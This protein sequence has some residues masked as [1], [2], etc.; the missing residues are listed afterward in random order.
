MATCLFFF[1]FSLFFPNTDQQLR[2]QHARLILERH[3]R[4]D[5]EAVLKQL[6]AEVDSLKTKQQTLINENNQLSLKV[7]FRAKEYDSLFWFS[8]K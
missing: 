8:T 1:F 6:Q 3:E 4:A 2:E 7:S 5:S